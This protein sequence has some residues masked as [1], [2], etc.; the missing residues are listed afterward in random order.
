[1]CPICFNAGLRHW[2]ARFESLG[3]EHDSYVKRQPVNRETETCD[4]I[5]YLDLELAIVHYHKLRS[6]RKEEHHIKLKPIKE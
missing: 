2:R 3:P 1:M 5:E 6:S 4:G